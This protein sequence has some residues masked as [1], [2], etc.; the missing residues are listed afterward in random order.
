MLMGHP[1]W[2]AEM[3]KIRLPY[4]INSLSQAGA[5]FCLD[6]Y[7]VLEAQGMRIREDRGQILA[8][9]AA[10]PGVTVYP[11][12]ANFI[13]IRFV[14]GADTVFE[15]LK[16]RGVLVK[17]L[18]QPGGMLENCL[19]ITVRDPR[20]KTWPC[21]MLSGKSWGCGPPDPAAAFFGGIACL[22]LQ[23]CRA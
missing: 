3:D 6:H 12:D 19:R 17:N 2:V 13:L 10:L 14:Q 8:E 5:A 9:L 18:H 4:N 1:D 15:S 23:Q 22:G 7:D 20:R 16:Q 21:W 11:S